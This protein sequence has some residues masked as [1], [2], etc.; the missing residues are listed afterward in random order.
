MLV[1]D[2]ALSA[3]LLAVAVDEQMVKH[4]GDSRSLYLDPATSSLL[5][6]GTRK[7]LRQQALWDLLLHYP[8]VLSPFDNLDVRELQKTGLISGQ[9][10][11]DCQVSASA[12]LRRSPAMVRGIRGLVLADLGDAH[13]GVITDD[14][15]G[16][17]LKLHESEGHRLSNRLE[18]AM[19]DMFETFEEYVAGTKAM[20]GGAVLQVPGRDGRRVSGEDFAAELAGATSRDGFLA[21]KAYQ[22]FRKFMHE[23]GSSAQ[24]WLALIMLSRQLGAVMSANLP[25]VL[26]RGD[27]P[28]RPGGFQN[29]FRIGAD[30]GSSHVAVRIWLEEV[31]CAP[32][33]TTIED[34]LRLRDDKRIGSFRTA[35]LEWT[36]E[37][38]CGSPAEEA[39]LR[40]SI[41]TANKELMTL[42]DVEKVSKYWTFASIPLDI[43]LSG[44]PPIVN[45]I[46]GFAVQEAAANKIRKL[47]WVMFGR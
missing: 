30:Q 36:Q 17:F 14:P 32:K 26:L 7:R 16:T 12:E 6:K 35:M 44:G 9:V 42:P 31:L 4:S 28:S 18:S 25:R 46:V 3:S 2:Q 13:R 1:L 11:L 29:D 21:F 24:R 34:V 5:A 19:F 43:L 15:V 38:A 20:F 40:K 45:S 39:R 27:R 8:A 22:P 47:D 41:R 33:L 37:L 23:F 10:G